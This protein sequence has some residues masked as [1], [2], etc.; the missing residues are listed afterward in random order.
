M[1]ITTQRASPALAACDSYETRDN[2]A[3]NE[4]RISKRIAMKSDIFVEGRIGG[5]RHYFSLASCIQMKAT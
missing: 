1:Q 3:E 5:G 2:G 4:S